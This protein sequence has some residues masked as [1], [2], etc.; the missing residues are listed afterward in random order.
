MSVVDVKC[1][2]EEL[3]P[4]DIENSEQVEPKHVDNVNSP[5]SHL[6]N[7]LVSGGGRQGGLSDNTRLHLQP[8]CSC[9]M[10]VLCT[11]YF[12]SPGRASGVRGTPTVDGGRLCG[13][14][15]EELR[16]ACLE[17]GELFTDPEFPPDDQSLYFSQVGIR[18]Y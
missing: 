14:N 8:P 3:S 7:N 6:L 15:F 12:V 18:T 10:D 1:L 13:Q 2:E 17:A 11:Y 9:S 4:E 16:A 5:F